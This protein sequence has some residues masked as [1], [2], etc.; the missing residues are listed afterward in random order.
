[1]TGD[2]F[3][4]DFMYD[5]KALNDAIRDHLTDRHLTAADVADSVGL[6]RVMVARSLAGTRP[7]RLAELADVAWHLGVHPVELICAA[8][9]EDTDDPW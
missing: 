5:E 9:P 1:M 8:F 4:D 2:A 7:W 6:G 3:H